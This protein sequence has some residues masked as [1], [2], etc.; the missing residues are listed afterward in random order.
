MQV[1]S[2]TQKLKNES[3]TVNS[4]DPLSKDVSEKVIQRLG[5]PPNFQKCDA[6]KIPNSPCYRVNVWAY[7]KETMRNPLPSSR[8]VDSFFVVYDENQ[9]IVSPVIEKK[10]HGK[11]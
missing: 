1:S 4:I 5:E 11:N 8:I 9:G 7:H 3:K 6:R 2:V 10:Y